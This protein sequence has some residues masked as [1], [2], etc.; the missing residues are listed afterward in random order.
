MDRIGNC[1]PNSVNQSYD[2]EAC[3][4]EACEAS[5]ARAKPQ[6]VASCPDGAV[7]D[8]GICLGTRLKGP[9]SAAER[10]IAHLAA[11]TEQSEAASGQDEQWGNGAAP[12]SEEAAGETW[13]E[14]IGDA[15]SVVVSAMRSA[16]SDG[17]VEAGKKLQYAVHLPDGSGAKFSIAG[18]TEVNAEG[19]PELVTKVTGGVNGKF[20]AVSAEAEFSFSHSTSGRESLSFGACVFGGV[21]EEAAELV[22]FEAKV[23]VCATLKDTTDE[24][25]TLEVEA[26][27]TSGAGFDLGGGLSWAHEFQA[28]RTLSKEHLGYDLVP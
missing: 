28:R 20:G 8:D 16:V 3:D 22:E 2:P 25:A 9:P 10:Y 6:P 5:S 11:M 13:Q 7:S 4:P 26:V 27:A 12:I 17:S 14:V 19:A 23:G 18:S 21:D 24:S 1:S 15:A